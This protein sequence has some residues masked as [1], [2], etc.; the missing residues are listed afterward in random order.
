MNYFLMTTGVLLAGFGAY[1]FGEWVFNLRKASRSTAWPQAK[2]K[3]LASVYEE[4]PVELHRIYTVN[5]NYEYEVGGVRYVSKRVSFGGH[6]ATTMEVKALQ[7]HA[8]YP[9]ENQVS[10]YYDPDKPAFAVLEPGVRFDRLWGGL[11]CFILGTVLVVVD[12]AV[13]E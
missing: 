13:S 7:A 3:I 11:F 10:V 12:F 4:K 9:P 5:L 6:I 2:G 8:R 1:L